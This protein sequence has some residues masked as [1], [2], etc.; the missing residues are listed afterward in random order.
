MSKK[1]RVSIGSSRS[2]LPL[3]GLPS[4]CVT[5]TPHARNPLR[6]RWHEKQ[7]DKI[8]KMFQD[9]HVNPETSCKSC[10]MAYVILLRDDY[11]GRESNC[12]VR[13]RGFVSRR[14]AVRS[15]S[16]ARH[17]QPALDSA[18]AGRAAARRTRLV[19]CD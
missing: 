19:Y 17:R 16:A 18:F 13:E 10:L 9:L 7:L 6:P 12:E 11:A 8:D 2:L 15:R 5:L 3:I 4:S 1:L 14:H